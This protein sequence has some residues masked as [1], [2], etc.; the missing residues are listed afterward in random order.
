ML[1]VEIRPMPGPQPSGQYYRLTSTRPGAEQITG[2]LDIYRQMDKT[3]DFILHQYLGA[4][5]CYMPPTGRLCPTVDAA[6]AHAANLFD[7]TVQALIS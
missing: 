6:L 1:P 4:R 5:E 3:Y 7:Q 2:H